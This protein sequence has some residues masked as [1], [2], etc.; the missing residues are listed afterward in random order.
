M[1]YVILRTL[2][3]PILSL[4]WRPYIVGW[5]NLR[6]KGKAIIAS[7]HTSMLDPIIIALVTPRIVHFMAKKEIF[8]NKI[9]GV[10]LRSLCVFPVKR[11]N[12]DIQSLKKA[13]R[14]LEKGKIFGIFPEGKRSVTDYMDKF[15]K[16]TA[17]IATKAGAPIL[18]IYIHP[19]S[20]KKGR[21]RMIVGKPI[22]VSD[23]V[24]NTKK[25]TLIDVVT[26]EISDA[27]DGLRVELEGIIEN[28]KR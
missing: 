6:I 9:V 10:F 12:A 3:Y 17:F 13:M 28:N 16:G 18:P 25:S 4:I 1:L 22:N 2:L 7:N 21:V 14:V 26:D 15:E 27:I 5:E 19:H 11:H 24:P 20:F 23:V 8:K